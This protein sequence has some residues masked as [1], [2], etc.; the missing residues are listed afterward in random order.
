M[1]N[2]LNISGTKEL[3]PLALVALAGVA[4]WYLW[5]KQQSDA[6]AADAA[7]SSTSNNAAVAATLN[8]LAS[9][10]GKQQ[11]AT[12]PTGSPS[13]IPGGAP[14]APAQAGITT[15]SSVAPSYVTQGL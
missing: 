6:M 3:V 1:F 14:N 10:S 15:S 2:F 13:V 8:V 7:S 9:L 5:K 12:T 11:G 4:I